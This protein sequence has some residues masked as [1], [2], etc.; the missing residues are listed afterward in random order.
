MIMPKIVTAP[1]DPRFPNV[2][3]ARHCFIRFNEY[4]K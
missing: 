1:F 4:Y 2:N 3:Q